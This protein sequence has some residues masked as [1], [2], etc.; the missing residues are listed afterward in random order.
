[1]SEPAWKRYRRYIKYIME[2]LFIERMR[3]LDFTMRDLSLTKTTGGLFHG[4][5]KTDEAHAK[6]IFD[7]I[8]VNESML[9]L[10]VGCGKGAF[11]REAS[12]YPFGKIAGIEYSEEL[13]KIG[14]K[15]FRLLKL[16]DKVKIYQA[17]AAEFKQYEQFNVFYFF[18]PFIEEIMEKV[19]KKIMES[20][21]G[22]FL[23]ILHNPVS[24][25][26]MERYGGIEIKR[27]Y[28]KVKSYETVIYRM[29]GGLPA[30]Q[31]PI[32]DIAESDGER[33]L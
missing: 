5:S 6:T 31:D 27:L 25:E 26:I 7:A 19:I 24:R 2:W 9:L 18:N 14:R 21:K 13:A 29:N 8:D 16:D 30:K 28:D 15:N 22:N 1:M 17:D 23:V 10:D 33:R 20:H 11:L 3:G 32:G 4:Y 12:R